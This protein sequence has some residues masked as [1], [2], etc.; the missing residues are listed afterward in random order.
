M[1]VRKLIKCLIPYGFFALSKRLKERMPLNLEFGKIAR[2]FKNEHLDNI[3]IETVNGGGEI[4]SIH[5]DGYEYPIHLRNNTTDVP[6]YKEVIERHEYS[7]ITK[8]EPEYIIDAGAN[9]GMAAIYF[10][11]KY[12]KAKIIAV[13]PESGNYDILKKNVEN[14]TNITAIKAALW[15]TSGEIF[16]FDTGLGNDGFMTEINQAVLKTSVKNIKET[17]KTITIDKIIND[18]HISSIDILKIDIEG[19]EKEV[20]ESCK[21]WINKTKCVIVEL[22]EKMKKGCNKAFSKTI[23]HF[24]KIGLYGEDIYLSRDNYIKI[25]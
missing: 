3:K 16:L 11:N 7:F 4:V 15:N 14:Y 22:H 8:Y 20:F 10:A 12:K 2:E 21:G 9:I 17:I 5:R 18:F 19:G 1:I 24:D 25:V 13:E 6:T 23:K